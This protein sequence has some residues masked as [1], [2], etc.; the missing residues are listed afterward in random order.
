MLDLSLHLQSMQLTL[1]GPAGLGASQSL[2]FQATG[3]RVQGP[4][5]HNKLL[6]I[7]EFFFIIRILVFL[8]S[9]IRREFN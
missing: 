5:V 4:T 2:K 1:K 9:E 6:V 8:S 3:K 7:P